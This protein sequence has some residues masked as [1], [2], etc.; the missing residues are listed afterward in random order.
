M[1]CVG[2]VLKD[3]KAASGMVVNLD[4]SEISFSCNT[5]GHFQEEL[6]RILGVWVVEKHV[7]YLGLPA[8]VGQSKKEIFHSLKDRIWKRLQSWRCKNLSQA[9]KA[10]LLQFVVQTM[11]T[12]VMGCFIIPISI[13]R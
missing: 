12:Y 7:K 8:L 10:V 13:C 3:F 6:A 11:P 5:P 4:K 9:G 2:R 1:T